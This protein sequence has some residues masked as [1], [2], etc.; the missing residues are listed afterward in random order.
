[1]KSMIHLRLLLIKKV[2]LGKV[3]SQDLRIVWEDTSFC[4]HVVFYGNEFLN[5]SERNVVIKSTHESAHELIHNHKNG[6]KYCLSAY[7][8]NLGEKNILP[9]FCIWTT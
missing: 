5:E 1:M 2:R 7:D 6:P 8:M 9:A 3:V 4:I